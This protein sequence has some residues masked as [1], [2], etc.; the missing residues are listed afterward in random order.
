MKEAMKPMTPLADYD[1]AKARAPEDD[2]A[3]DAAEEVAA[4]D[5][6]MD[7]PMDMP[8]ASEVLGLDEDVD[9]MEETAALMDDTAAMMQAV[10]DEA[11]DEEETIVQEYPEETQPVIEED[12]MSPVQIPQPGA[13]ESKEPA[14]E[15]TADAAMGQEGAD[16]VQIE[17]D[18]AALDAVFEN[19]IDTNNGKDGPDGPHE[20]HAAPM[21]MV[22]DSEIPTASLHP[23]Y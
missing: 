23:D 3:E 18:K 14:A 6:A 19:W 11:G 22:E 17:A 1:E 9:A 10:V 2:A 13:A 20:E 12:T 21:P 8:A 7:D 5:P 16:S 4:E 15:D